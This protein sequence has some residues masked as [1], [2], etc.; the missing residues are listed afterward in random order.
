MPFLQ[1]FRRQNR[2]FYRR[3]CLPGKHIVLQKGYAESWKFQLVALYTKSSSHC[4]ALVQ[5]E[6]VEIEGIKFLRGTQVTGK[7]GHRMEGKRTLIPFEHI[8]S[9]VEFASEDDLWSEPQPR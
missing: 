3:V 1:A 4:Y 8:G 9:I 7:V 2:R 6:I 5:A